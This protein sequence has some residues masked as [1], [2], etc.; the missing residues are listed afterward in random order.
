MS[1]I[2]DSQRESPVRRK[3]FVTKYKLEGRSASKQTNRETAV[4]HCIGHHELEDVDLL[5]LTVRCAN[6]AYFSVNRCR[7][8]GTL[9]QRRNMVGIIDTTSVCSALHGCTEL[10]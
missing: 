8:Q 2:S 10:E 3:E 9:V 1:A 7:C 4:I 5:S 6:Y